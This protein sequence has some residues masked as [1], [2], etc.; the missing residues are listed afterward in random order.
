MAF[1]R[2]RRAALDWS[3]YAAHTDVDRDF[4][5]TMRDGTYRG[6]YAGSGVNPGWRLQ[7]AVKPAP[8]MAP[9]AD[10][11][12][13]DTGSARDAASSD[14]SPGRDAAVT[15]DA[16]DGPMPDAGMTGPAIDA[17]GEEPRTGTDGGCR[18]LAVDAGGEEPRTGTGGGCRSLAV[19]GAASLWFLGLGFL[20][21][22]RRRQVAAHPSRRVH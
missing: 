15:A 13:V 14:A 18:S 12:V 9:V 20:W 3:D 19:D 8:G 6:A 21:L 16:A 2:G 7:A 17:G 10:A 4:D 5:H 11:G 22:A 1:A